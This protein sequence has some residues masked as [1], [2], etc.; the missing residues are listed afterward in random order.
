M[1]VF[2]DDA[3]NSSPHLFYGRGRFAHL[4]ADTRDELHVFAA[5][6][7]LRRSWFEERP[8][9]WHYDV[10]QT[11]RAEAIALGA[12]PVTTREFIRRLR[13]TPSTR[14]GETER[15]AEPEDKP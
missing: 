4:S 11:K 1:S 8:R 5:R 12:E 7:G 14:Q 13:A 2:V 3:Q 9:L 6:L 15:P 10:T